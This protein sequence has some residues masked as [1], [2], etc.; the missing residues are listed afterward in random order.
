MSAGKTGENKTFCFC[1][2]LCWQFTVFLKIL[3]I[4][5][6]K[7]QAAIFQ[8][9]NDL[10]VN[11]SNVCKTIPHLKIQSQDGGNVFLFEVHKMYYVP[12][13]DCS[14]LPTREILR[15]AILFA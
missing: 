10:D 2:E 9:V 14:K 13:L 5:D 3:N 1:F 12:V 6:T 7:Q 8:T 4:Q 15:T 11:L